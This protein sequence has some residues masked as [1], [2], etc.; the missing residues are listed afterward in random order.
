MDGESPEEKEARTLSLW[1]QL[2]TQNEGFLDL[3]ALKKGLKKL[4][5]REL[6]CH[7]AELDMRLTWAC[8]SSIEACR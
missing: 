1:K 6:L 4:D 8:L 3:S 5:H 2:D 7:Q